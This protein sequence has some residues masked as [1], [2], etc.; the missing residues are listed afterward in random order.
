LPTAPDDIPV[1]ASESASPA[2]PVPDLATPAD[3]PTLAPPPVSLTVWRLAAPAISPEEFLADPYPTLFTKSSPWMRVVVHGAVIFFVTTLL[4]V[5][6]AEGWF[7]YTYF[8]HAAAMV[9][10]MVVTDAIFFADRKAPPR[11]INV[12]WNEEGLSWAEGLEVGLMRWEDM[13]ERRLVPV[14]PVLPGGTQRL[15]VREALSRWIFWEGPADLASQV[16]NSWDEYKER[17]V[18]AL[19]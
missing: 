17:G 5:A 2:A 12:Q 11:Q 15:L 7:G 18:E 1:D 9:L 10:G 6:E 4:F 13:R 3:A 16:L 19:G 8:V 14:D